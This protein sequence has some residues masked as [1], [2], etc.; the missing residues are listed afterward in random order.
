MT[1]EKYTIHSVDGLLTISKQQTMMAAQ[2]TLPGLIDY[3]IADTK[4][5]EQY[6]TYLNVDK[7]LASA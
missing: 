3:C 4:I 5:E 6:Q 1:S 7:S 2:L